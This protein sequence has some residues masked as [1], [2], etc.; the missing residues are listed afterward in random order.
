[1]IIQNKKKN[2]S[3]KLKIQKIEMKL[4]FAYFQKIVFSFI[5]MELP[6]KKRI[7]LQEA[8]YAFDYTISMLSSN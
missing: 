6:L 1:M 5:L 7:G 3:N 4:H 2:D 8:K